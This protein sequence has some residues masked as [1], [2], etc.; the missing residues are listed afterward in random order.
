MVNGNPV[1]IDRDEGGTILLPIPPE[2]SEV[3]L[4][5]EEPEQMGIADTRFA[6][7]LAFLV[8]AA[9]YLSFRPI[10]DREEVSS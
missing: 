4:F 6:L 7:D 2:R 3:R 10:T 5:F 8:T 1:E 9:V